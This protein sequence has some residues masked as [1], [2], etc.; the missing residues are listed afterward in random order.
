[1]GRHRWPE[2]AWQLDQGPRGQT[3]LRNVASGKLLAN[4]QGSRDNGTEIIQWREDGGPEQ[5][6]VLEAGP[7]GGV[8]IRNVASSLLL[9]NPQGS[10]DNGTTII[11]WQD[12]GGAEQ[13]WVFEPPVQLAR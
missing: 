7:R 13:E 9:A 4:P 5:E 6:W 8:R 12:D 10:R 11:Q 2:Q 3:R 1:M